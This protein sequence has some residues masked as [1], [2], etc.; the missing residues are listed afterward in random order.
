MKTSW[1]FTT[2]DDQKMTV[3]G[4]EILRALNTVAFGRASTDHEPSPVHD[5][6]T[7]KGDT[8][9]VYYRLK[10]M[11]DFFSFAWMLQGHT[12]KDCT[13]HIKKSDGS[14][15]KN[16]HVLLGKKSRELTKIEDP[17][18]RVVDFLGVQASYEEVSEY[19]R[20]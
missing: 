14:Q 16:I 1:E 8:I 12:G 9:D 2:E 13:R 17:Y 18:A 5:V 4:S 11:A 7:E 19:K 20:A 15:A 6:K 10:G 3:E